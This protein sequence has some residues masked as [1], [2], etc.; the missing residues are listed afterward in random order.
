MANETTQTDQPT[1]EQVVPEA[2]GTS[3]STT[4]HVKVYSPFHVY[5]D[6]QAESITAENAT[7][8]FDILPVTKTSSLF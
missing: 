7:G 3:T 2:Q 4:M 6:G 1:T 5:F 8:Q